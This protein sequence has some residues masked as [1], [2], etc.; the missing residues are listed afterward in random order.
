MAQQSYILAELDKDDIVWLLESGTKTS[1][2][3]G[4]TIIAENQPTEAFYVV[5]DGQFEIRISALNNQTL[6]YAGPAEVLGEMSFVDNRPPSATVVADGD[7]TVLTIPREAL[8]EK[9]DTDDAFAKRFYR[10]LA[11]FMADRLRDTLS[12][13]RDTRP[14]V[15]SDTLDKIMAYLRAM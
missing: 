9:I 8:R 2:P 1:I 7:A 4:T 6:T 11:I 3:D 15:Q 14:E 5:I 10:A 13:E 12:P